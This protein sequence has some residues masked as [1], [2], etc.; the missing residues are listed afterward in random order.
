MKIF[1]QKLLKI[2]AK[3]ILKRHKPRIIGITGSVGK[4]STKEAVALVLSKKYKIRKTFGNYNNEIGLPL[5][6]IG[7]KTAGK[8]IFGWFWILAKGFFLG[9][10]GRRYPEI[11]VLEMGVDRPD[12][13]DYLID[14]AKPD[15]AVVTAI[16]EIPVHLEFFKNAEELALEKGKIVKCLKKENFAILNYDDQRVKKL[17]SQTKAQVL[18]FG[19][20]EKADFWASNLTLDSKEL[21][22]EKAKPHGI[23][24]KLHSGEREMP[25]RLPYIFGFPQ[26]YSVFA[27]CVCGTVFKMNLVEVAEQLLQFKPPKGRMNLIAGIKH[28]NIIDDSY[29]ASPQSTLAALKVLGSLWPA[30][31]KIAILGDML[32]LGTMTEEGHRLVGKEAA[33][34]CQHLICVGNA[35][36]FIA[37]EARKS[38]MA[39]DRVF[40][41][42]K[43]KAGEAAKFVQNKILRKGDLVLIKGSQ[44]MK[45]EQAVKELMAEP[46]RA[47]ELLVRQG[48]EWVKRD[49]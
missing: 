42:E 32:E 45:L 11:L 15:V 20:N 3:R 34:A 30:G 43:D 33:K 19:V 26:V 7:E 41:F 17:R 47:G 18:T 36:K 35:A 1:L 6:I 39:P 25:F 2:I 5:T 48:K 16:S 27:A 8:N 14:L 12:D 38:G 24:F 40:E 31:S 21:F 29:N 9:T 22:D 4:T 28:T 44:G 46:Q 49:E 37:D 23:R 10:F 13:M